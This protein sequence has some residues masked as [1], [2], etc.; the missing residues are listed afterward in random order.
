MNFDEYVVII[1][2]LLNDNRISKD[3]YED[4]TKELW[5]WI[6]FKPSRKKVGLV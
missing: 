6:D 4:L 5:N 1:N 3:T 2:F